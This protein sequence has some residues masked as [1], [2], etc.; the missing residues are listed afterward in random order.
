MEPWAQYQ[1]C[2]RRRTITLRL[3]VAIVKRSKKQVIWHQRATI[4]N[5]T[6]ATATRL[7]VV[8]PLRSTDRR[9]FAAAFAAA[10]TA[11]AVVVFTTAVAAADTRYTWSRAVTH[12]CAGALLF[13]HRHEI[14]TRAGAVA[15]ARDIRFSTSGRLKRISVLT[16]APTQP[17]VAAH[18]LRIERQLALVYARSYLHIFDVIDA[19]RTPRQREREPHLLGK[20]LH[21]PDRLGRVA[22]RLQAALHVPD[23]TGGHPEAVLPEQD[24]PGRS[25][26]VVLA[27]PSGMSRRRPSQNSP[28]ES[29][30]EARGHG[31]RGRATGLPELRQTVA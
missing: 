14:G 31:T 3:T 8:G 25:V 22:V 28:L 7:A 27:M 29:R 19:A 13:D 11:A 15:V 23:C 18:W 24:G 2:A 16:V 9:L 4:S 30:V 26:A 20:L 21:A 6:N 17:R 12:I 10:A 1:G 5:A